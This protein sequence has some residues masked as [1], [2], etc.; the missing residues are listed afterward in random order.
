MLCFVLQQTNQSSNRW[1]HYG[2][3]GNS[4]CAISEGKSGK[5]WLYPRMT[6]SRKWHRK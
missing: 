1:F 3:F 6:E 4:V 2:D 5:G